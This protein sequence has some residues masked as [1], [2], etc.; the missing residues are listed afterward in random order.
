MKSI[1]PLFICNEPLF[2]SALAY[3]VLVVF[4]SILAMTELAKRLFSSKVTLPV[5]QFVVVFMYNTSFLIGLEG[6]AFLLQLFLHHRNIVFC[7]E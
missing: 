5:P 6:Y 7:L 1:L 4:A 3:V 2:F